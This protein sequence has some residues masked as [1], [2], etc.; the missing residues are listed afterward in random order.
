MPFPSYRPLM[1]ARA[2]KA[3]KNDASNPHTIRKG[4]TKSLSNERI[5]HSIYHRAAGSNTY[6]SLG[7]EDKECRLQSA[8]GCTN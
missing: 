6:V 8:T 2:R 3:M 1:Y 7:E 4:P 5:T